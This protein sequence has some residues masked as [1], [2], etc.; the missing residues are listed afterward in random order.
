VISGH[1]RP[2]ERRGENS[3]PSIFL[4]ETRRAWHEVD[5]GTTLHWS[6]IMVFRTCVVLALLIAGA[7]GATPDALGQPS[8]PAGEPQPAPQAA[9]ATEA[10]APTAV[11]SV[12]R[13]FSFGFALGLGKSGDSLENDSNPKTYGVFARFRI[14]QRW[15]VEAG[16]SKLIIDL[17]NER[18]RDLTPMGASVLYHIRQLGELDLHLRAGYA[19]AK[20]TYRNQAA[21]TVSQYNDKRAHAGAGAEYPVW[22]N[23]YAS[24]LTEAFWLKRDD[25]DL[26]ATGLQFIL[27]AAYHF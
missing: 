11:A 18:T 1:S 17:G 16:M 19:Q 2:G 13:R 7:L 21:G 27:A 12:L 15:E 26:S 8:V 3:A 6:S 25:S 22:E 23:I 9:P 5:E 4:A 10:P 24:A 20:E 14:S